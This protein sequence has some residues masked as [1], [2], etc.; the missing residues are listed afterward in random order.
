MAIG[1]LAGP[2]AAATDG[3]AADAAKCKGGGYL[4][5]TDANGNAFKNVGQCT[6]YAARGGQLVPVPDITLDQA[7]RTISGTGFTPN[8][9]I[10]LMRH[11]YPV[12]WGFMDT[13][14]KTD[15][16]GGFSVSGFNFCWDPSNSSVSVYAFDDAGLSTVSVEETFALSCGSSR[17]ASS[18]D[19]D[20]FG[21]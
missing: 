7:S 8:S 21:E 2:V 9:T 3:N 15:V 19:I 4:G 20:R 5:Y 6:S 1:L 13:Y 10:T 17:A 18:S 12:G 11:Y 14:G 16:T